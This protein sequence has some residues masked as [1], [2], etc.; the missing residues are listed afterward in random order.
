MNCT[1]KVRG[2]NIGGWLVAE[3]WITPSLFDNTRDSRVIDEYTLGRY[4]KDACS[5]LA[6]HWASFITESDFQQIAAANLNFVRIPIGYWALDNKHTYY[7][8]GNQ[9]G[10]LKQA[11]V[12]ARNAGLKVVIDLHGAVGSQNGF[13]NSGKKGKLNWFTQESYKTRTIAVIQSLAQT[14]ANDY[15]TVASI[16]LLNEPLT[17]AGPSNAVPF[18]LDFCNKGISAV[19]SPSGGNTPSDYAVMIHDGFQQLSF[20]NG[21]YPAPQ[22]EQILLDTHIYS[23]FDQNLLYMSQPDRAQFYCNKKASIAS[24]NQN[25]WTIVGEWTAAPTDCAKY[26]NGRGVGARYDGTFPGSQKI[27][28]CKGMTGSG[29]TF[30][31]SYKAYLK[32]MF[33]TQ[34]VV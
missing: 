1:D 7:C 27:G 15:D 4:R 14:F 33:D 21:R 32:N 10:Y 11:V 9:L 22:Y 8:Q 19:R 31:D 26:L 34:R 25:L 20:W 16:E 30:S 17:T 24:S 2:V 12:W 29:A 6:R 23:V 28:T 3:P 13:D 18:M 5:R